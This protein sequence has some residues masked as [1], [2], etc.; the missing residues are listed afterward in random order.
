MHTFENNKF[1][2]F[3]ACLFLNQ[4]ACR[5]SNGQRE[6]LHIENNQNPHASKSLNDHLEHQEDIETEEKEDFE[7]KNIE[8]EKDHEGVQASS[9]ISG[10]YLTACAFI[11]NRANVLC[12]FNSDLFKKEA[13]QQRE[14][15]E[16]VVIVRKDQ[17][18]LPVEYVLQYYD[19][20]EVWEIK[21][22]R[23]NFDKPQIDWTYC[24]DKCER[25]DSMPVHDVLVEIDGDEYSENDLSIVITKED[26]LYRS[27]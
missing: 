21:I 5:K 14:M 17:R 24:N 16:I 26:S 4:I 22:P 15:I 1:I 7:D 6:V 13:D 11:E 2:L 27:L 23:E 12:E 8:E 18:Y 3:C 20:D 10:S 19:E 9:M 25:D